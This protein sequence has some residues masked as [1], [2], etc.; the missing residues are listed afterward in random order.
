M[1]TTDDGTAESVAVTTWIGGGVVAVTV[2]VNVAERL[3]PVVSVAVT[4]TE[5][6]PAA[7]G[8]PE[9]SPVVALI[10]RPVG[11]PTAL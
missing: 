7:V 9:I 2:Q 11:N 4:V 3:A 1:P 8:V 10:V 6:E 5:L